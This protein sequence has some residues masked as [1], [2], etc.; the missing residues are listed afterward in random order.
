VQSLWRVACVRIPR[1]PIGAVWRAARRGEAGMAA[2]GGQLLLPFSQPESSLPSSP[3]GSSAPPSSAPAHWDDVAIALTDAAGR[4]LQAASA[5]AGRAG[6]RAGMRPTEARALCAEL[7]ELPW[8]DVAVGAAITE[9]SAQLLAASPQVTPVAGAPGL[10]WVGATGFDAVGGE[11]A[12]AHTLLRVA[13]RWHP[14]PRVAIAGSCVAARAATWAGA[15]FEQRADDRALVH[16]VPPGGDAAYLAPAPLALVPM[17]DE[18]RA[19]LQALGLRS[20]GMLAALDAE[21]IERRWGEVGLRAWR[22]A[23]ADDPRRPVL[24]RVETQPA[25]EVELASPA[26][27]MEPVL[28]LVRAALDRLV[29]QMIAHGRAVAAVAITLTLDDARGPTASAPAHTVTREARPARPLARVLPLFERCRALLD[30]WTL[31]APVMAVRV[32][33]VAVAPLT[34]E[35]GD[36]LSASWRDLGA[37]DAALERLRAELGTGAIVRAQA[38]DTH[39]PEKA[40]IWRE[41]QSDGPTV[42]Q[43]PGTADLS[44]QT[45]VGPSDR[46]T[47]RPVLRLISPL[48][49]HRSPFTEPA[50]S[51]PATPA[52]RRALDPPEPVEVVC[53][54]ETPRLVTWRGQ[55]IAIT[56]ALGPERLSGDWWDDGYR[57]D[58]WRCESTTGELTLYRDR[59]D[60]AWRLQSWGD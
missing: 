28:F 29:Q 47:I 14:R 7:V 17:D 26:V 59:S 10:W 32:A 48:T 18:L 60:D 12:L 21:D 4:R 13:R 27:T 15:S 53:E 3:R 46:E 58:Y 49:V 1:F 42:G 45:T 55:H 38:R 43:S 22:L 50:A 6:V 11:R 44:R 35:Q 25:V 57:R 20:V 37:A 40:G 39:R 30:T 41:L 5:A 8:D 51:L 2:A 34:G 31:E 56:R 9:A 24:A 54:D 36:L 16:V 19:A 52:A 23:R 33:I